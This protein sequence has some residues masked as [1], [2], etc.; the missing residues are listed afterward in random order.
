MPVKDF[1]RTK[2]DAFL[3]SARLALLASNAGVLSCSLVSGLL[4]WSETSH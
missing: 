1:E 4:F 2:T 3:T